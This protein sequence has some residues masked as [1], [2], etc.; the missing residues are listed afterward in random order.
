ML[1][2]TY[3]RGD[4]WRPNQIR[5]FMLFVRKK[6][7]GRLHAYAWVAELQRRGA[8]H[9]H[10]LLIVDKGTYIPKPDKGCWWPWGST[11]IET[12][13]SPFYI[14]KYVGKEYQKLGPF[15]KGMRMFSVWVAEDY[16]TMD[17][18]WFFRLSTLPAWFRQVVLSLPEVYGSRWSRS[19]GG[20]WEYN[21]VVHP[22]PYELITA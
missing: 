1:T 11:R 19:P 15:P 21:G 17:D 20:G 18:R 6:L 16:I 3:E 22:S 2:L 10:V 12:A 9:Y 7:K 14:A 4:D 13:K 8:V 5:A